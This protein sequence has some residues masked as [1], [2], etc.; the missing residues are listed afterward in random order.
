MHTRFLNTLPKKNQNVHAGLK[1]CI[2]FCIVNFLLI[3]ITQT[4]CKKDSSPT[5]TDTIPVP[6]KDTVSLIRKL[7]EVYQTSA[8]TNPVKNISFYYDNQKRI[9]TLGIKNYNV[10]FDTGTVRFFYAGSQSQ[11]AMVICPNRLYSQWGNGTMVYDTSYFFYN[12]AGQIT[13]DSSYGLQTSSGNTWR[14]LLVRRYNYTAANLLTIQML[15]D[16]YNSNILTLYR[17]DTVTCKPDST[18]DNIKVAYPSLA[19]THNYAML[20]AF[21]YSGYLNPLAKLNIS[22]LHY[23]WVNAPN[24]MEILGNNNYKTISNTNI[25]AYYIDFVSPSIPTIFF[26]S[27]YNSVGGF[28]NGDEF[29]ITVLPWTQRTNYP[30]S[31]TVTG[32]SSYTG[33]KFIYY[34]S[35]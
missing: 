16:A 29:D 23:S 35:Y 5:P 11:P 1:A 18:F 25:L 27:A 3:I 6:S 28:I 32:S 33:D 22:G 19:N 30:R 4:S 34:Y 12:T 15:K 31:V 26:N 21:N 10:L 7:E 20:Q 8:G 2:Y 17:S 13:K 14:R 9:T 24:D